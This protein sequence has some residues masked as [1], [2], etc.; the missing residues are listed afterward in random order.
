[1]CGLR[2]GGKVQTM[3]CCRNTWANQYLAQ[4]RAC[5]TLYQVCWVPSSAFLLSQVRLHFKCLVYRLFRPAVLLA[6]GEFRFLLKQSPRQYS[7][8][9]PTDNTSASTLQRLAQKNP[10]AVP[11]QRSE[12]KDWQF[13]RGFYSLL[14]KALPLLLPR[15]SWRRRYGGEEYQRWQKALQEHQRDLGRPPLLF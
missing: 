5:P 7:R 11:S 8:R 9:K 2:A 13:A 15:K 10:Y 3:E 1:M 4:W 6:F 12:K 14:L